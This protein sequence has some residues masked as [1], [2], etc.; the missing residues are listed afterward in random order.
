MGVN[1]INTKFYVEGRKN[2]EFK[3]FIKKEYND[4]EIIYNLEKV[5][6]K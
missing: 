5:Y 2:I 1:K 3:Y 6:E 4:I